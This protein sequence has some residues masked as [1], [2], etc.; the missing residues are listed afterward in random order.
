MRD[1]TLKYLKALY[2]PGSQG[3]FALG[4][5]KRPVFFRS[6][7]LEAAA[8]HALAVDAAGHS[9]YASVCAYAGARRLQNTAVSG[10]VLWVDIDRQSPGHAADNL[11]ATIEDLVSLLRPLPLEPSFITDT[12]GGWHVYWRINWTDGVERL[13][14]VDLSD[15]RARVDF[16][17]TVKALQ[18]KVIETAAA[19]GWHVDSLS[20]LS[21]FLRPTGTHNHKPGRDAVPL[22]RFLIEPEE[23]PVYSF[24]ALRTAFTK[25]TP[26][27]PRS[28]PPAPP[29]QRPAIFGPAP[30]APAVP[31]ADEEP[32]SPEATQE[33]VLSKARRNRHLDRAPVLVA[34]LDGK[35]FAARGERDS[36]A[37]RLASW[38]AFYTGGLGDV[39]AIL[40]LAEPSLKTME[41]ESPEDFLTEDQFRDKLERA[42][43]DALRIC[44]DARA[45]EA[46][47]RIRL[48]EGFD[49][50]FS[51]E[52]GKPTA[53]EVRESAQVQHRAHPTT[54]TTAAPE[55]LGRVSRPASVGASAPGSA[56]GGSGGREAG[57]I[58]GR[59]EAGVIFGGA[60]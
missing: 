40:E 28:R 13:G 51:P 45:V 29:V 50:K 47:M 16:K 17:A 55:A 24:E 12:G 11:P 42:M 20:D 3:F 33:M 36:T 8:D 30:G 46:A 19:H 6:D 22:V 5:K 38:L 59:R 52:K 53:T 58:S 15:Q 31:V 23:G 35:T 48:K 25:G 7:E 60:R 10:S 57:V 54:D 14:P 41:A 9:A 21:R 49:K 18:A 1:L 32:L 37:Q 44:R 56:P 27:A 34:L 39:D 2:P 43:G 26:T 4:D